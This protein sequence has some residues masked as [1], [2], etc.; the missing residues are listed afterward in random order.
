MRYWPTD[1][2]FVLVGDGRTAVQQ[3]L[4]ELARRE[5][6]AARVL[7]VGRVPYTDVLSFAVGASLG[8]TL[9]DPI[10]SNLELCAGASNKRFEYAALGI[11]QVTN[12]GAGMQRLFESPGIAVLVDVADVAMIGQTIAQLLLNS[13]L[14][15]T[16]GERARSVH[17]SRYNYETQFAPVVECINKWVSARK[18]SQT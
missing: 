12:S 14:A 7:F 1:A 9:L 5:A 8:V 3:E 16:I 4:R 2:V 13:S 18:V 11:P 15:S 6:V 17:L 10:N